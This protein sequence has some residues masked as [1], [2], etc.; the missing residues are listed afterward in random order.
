MGVQL[1]GPSFNQRKDTA[2]K[3][4]IKTYGVRGLME[5]VCSIP[6]GKSHM[7]IEFTGGVLTSYGNTPAKFVTKDLLQ[8]A[9]IE[10]SDLFKKGRIVL[11]SVMETDEEEDRMVTPE[12]SKEETQE[13]EATNEPSTVETLK[14]RAKA[15][16]EPSENEVTEQPKVETVTTK[17]FTCND[18]AKDFLETEFGAKRSSMRTRADI[19]SIGKTYGVEVKFAD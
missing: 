16:S 14:Q 7:R 2:M 18:D 3:K 17:E 15:A 8:Q 19:I 13:D 6:V 1:I 10:N 9:I 4:K 11:L 5:W 12:P